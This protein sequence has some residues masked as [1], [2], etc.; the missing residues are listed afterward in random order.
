MNY[1]W[2]ATAEEKGRVEG[3]YGGLRRQGPKG[4]KMDGRLVLLLI[5]R[6]DPTHTTQSRRVQCGQSAHAPPWPG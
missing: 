3:A 5:L 1:E 4:T 2:V 6:Q